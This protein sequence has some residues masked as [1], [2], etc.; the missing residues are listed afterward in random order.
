MTIAGR[1]WGY[2]HGIAKKMFKIDLVE[3]CEPNQL[4][5]IVA[6]L[7]Y[8]RRRREAKGAEAAL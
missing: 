2:A 1:P 8:D 3:W 5:R 4:W 6:A 7:E